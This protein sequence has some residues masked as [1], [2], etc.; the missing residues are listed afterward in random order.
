MAR[1]ERVGNVTPT[2]THYKVD[3]YFL[4]FPYLKEKKFKTQAEAEA[5]R[6]QKEE[7]KR[8]QLFGG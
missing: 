2:S 5:Y 3:V 8:N 4:G 1:I 6:S 7:E